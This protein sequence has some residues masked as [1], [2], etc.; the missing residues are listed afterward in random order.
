MKQ[1][2]LCELLVP[3]GP[4]PPDRMYSSPHPKRKTE[5]NSETKLAYSAAG[6][7]SPH[8][9]HTRKETFFERLERSRILEP[10][11]L[12]VSAAALTCSVVILRM[13]DGQRVQPWRV[14]LS[15]LVSWLSTIARTGAILGATSGISQLK[16]TWFAEQKRELVDLR[17][18][19]VASRGIG[20]SFKLLAR[21]KTMRA[22][23]LSR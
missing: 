5:R 13:Q 20:G 3:N 1:P 4:D 17:I 7:I 6:P 11:G 21:Q 22:L 8:A 15:S 14:S 23:P 16:W 9:P 19:D 10:L 18:Y 12:L 2:S